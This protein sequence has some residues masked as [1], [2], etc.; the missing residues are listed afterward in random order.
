MK[1][2]YRTSK[3]C[4]IL[5]FCEAC[6]KE[7]YRCDTLHMREVHNMPKGMG[8]CRVHSNSQK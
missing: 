8:S 6:E 2:K 4:L 3:N 1:K 7:I 5:T